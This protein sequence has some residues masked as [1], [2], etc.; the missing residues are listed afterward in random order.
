MAW[1]TQRLGRRAFK[2]LNG[3]TGGLSKRVVTG[4]VIID[5]SN[6]NTPEAQDAIYKEQ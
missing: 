5:N 1:Q 6:G 3:E 4:Y 2:A